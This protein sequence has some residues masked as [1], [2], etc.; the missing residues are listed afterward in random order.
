MS[1]L[2]V[3]VGDR[4][5]LLHMGPDDPDPIPPGSEG[6]VDYVNADP[7]LGQIGVKW[8]NG[9]S[10]MLIPGVDHFAVIRHG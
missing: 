10:L 5:R 8:D 3:K 1:R 4:I 6:T 9:R 7:D 2:D